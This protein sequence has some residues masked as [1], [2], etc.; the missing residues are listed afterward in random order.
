[1][2]RSEPAVA[3]R[4]EDPLDRVDVAEP[5]ALC[6]EPPARRQDG[7]EVREERIVVGHPVEG[8]RRDD[9]VHRPVE[10]QWPRRGRRRRTRS[11][12]RKARAAPSR[13]RSSTP[14]HRAPRPARAEAV[15]RGAPSPGHCRTR[16]RGR[17]RRRRAAVGRGRPRP[18]ASSGRRRGR[19]SAHPTRASRHALPLDRRRGTRVPGLPQTDPHGDGAREEQTRRRRSSRGGRRRSMPGWPRR[20]VRATPQPAAD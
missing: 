6:D 20:P 7:G 19:T 8:R 13:L 18:S 9:R 16:R 17:A 1:M 15:P 11:G 10:R 2:G 5:A 12:R 14:S 4:R 3:D